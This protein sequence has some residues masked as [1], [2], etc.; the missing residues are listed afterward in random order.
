MHPVIAKLGAARRPE[1]FANPHFAPLS[2]DRRV[3]LLDEVM[4]V[5]ASLD[6]DDKF[7]AFNDQD[8]LLADAAKL[9]DAINFT[10]TILGQDRRIV[11][12][13]VEGLAVHHRDDLDEAMRE[14][15]AC[16]ETLGRMLAILERLEPEPEDDRQRRTRRNNGEAALL[17]RVLLAFGVKVSMTTPS[18]HGPPNH[19]LELIGLFADPPASADV[20]RNRLRR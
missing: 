6:S 16:R 7:E 3:Q 12:D 15:L 14:E 19:G 2:A 18:K 4:K 20:I 10:L 5:R 11:A 9:K 1:L 17:R 13:I 8:M